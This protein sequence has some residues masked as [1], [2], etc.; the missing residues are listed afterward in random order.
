MPPRRER[1][2]TEGIEGPAEPS[3]AQSQEE[4]T[5]TQRLERRRAELLQKRQLECIQELEQ[6]LTGGL[7]ASSMAVI[8]EE[9]IT[10]LISYQ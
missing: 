1:Q 2:Q 3:V 7:Q 4:D 8:D 9:F 6:E 5:V 10:L